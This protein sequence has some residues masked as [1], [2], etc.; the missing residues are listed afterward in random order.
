MDIS[1]NINA[2]LNKKIVMIRYMTDLEMQAFKWSR[3]AIIFQLED[4]TLLFP[5]IDE[6][7]TNAGFQMIMEKNGSFIPL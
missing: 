1:N 3:K 7:G 5:S 2:I 4:G 6:E